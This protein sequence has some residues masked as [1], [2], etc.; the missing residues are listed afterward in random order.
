[1][2]VLA[3]YVHP[4]TSEL[5]ENKLRHNFLLGDMTWVK[6]NG[7]SWWPAQVWHRQFASTLI[8]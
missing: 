4:S 3:K 8:S 7:T 5:P 1:M 6:H 2:N